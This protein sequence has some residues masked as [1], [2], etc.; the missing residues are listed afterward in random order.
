VLGAHDLLLVEDAHGWE[1]DRRP[2]TLT[3]GRRRWGVIRSVSRLLGSDLRVAFVAG[4]Q[5]T[6]ARVEARQAVTTSWV[7]RLLQE[8]I[9]EML[10]GAQV[11]RELRP[12]AAETD[13]R[14]LALLAALEQRGVRAHGARAYT[15]GS[16]CVGRASPSA[17][18]STPAIRCYP[19]SDPGCTRHRRCGVTTSQLPP[20]EAEPLADALAEAA[21]GRSLIS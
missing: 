13:E 4:D 11:R 18:S 3:G 12:A 8:V 16:R 15:S 7:S 14:R 6:I 21:V 1:I 9:A 19:E 10:T 17:T 5:E 20:A 2:L